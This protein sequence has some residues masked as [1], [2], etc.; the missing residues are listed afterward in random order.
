MTTKAIATAKTTINT[1]VI[2]KMTI[3]M[4]TTVMMMTTENTMMTNMIGIN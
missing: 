2:A 1:T 4:T 3:R